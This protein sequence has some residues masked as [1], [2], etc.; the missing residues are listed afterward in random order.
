MRQ[1]T[2]FWPIADLDLITELTFTL[3]GEVSIEHLQ[4]VRTEDA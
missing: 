4:R 2:K 3:L 1:Y